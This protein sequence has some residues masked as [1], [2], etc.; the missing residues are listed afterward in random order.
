MLIFS[1]LALGIGVGFALSYAS[2]QKPPIYWGATM[3]FLSICLAIFISSA[4]AA[5]S[6]TASD[7]IARINRDGGK[8][9]LADLWEHEP[10]FDAVI[11][12]IESANRD[13]LQVAA[14][15]K[16]FSDAGSSEQIDMAVGRAL[17]K[18]PQ[19][20]LHLIGH[21]GFQLDFVC[22][23]PFDEP[24]PGV[25]KEYERR[26]LAALATLNDPD[27]KSVAAECAKHIKLPDSA[28]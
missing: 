15:L 7:M 25:A 6:I 22:T 10:E 14:L 24:A 4:L 8:Q 12:G 28:N 3:R 18:D 27:L 26:A 9:V 17:P 21:N 13:W 23:S 16:P 2:R 20:V 19:R 5:D 11:S 1:A